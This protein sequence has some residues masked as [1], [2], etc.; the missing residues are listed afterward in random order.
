MNLQQAKKNDDFVNWT[1]F[2][3]KKLIIKC[4]FEEEFRRLFDKEKRF[5]GENIENLTNDNLRRTKPLQQ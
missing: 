4:V 5:F 2:F 3:V 1:S